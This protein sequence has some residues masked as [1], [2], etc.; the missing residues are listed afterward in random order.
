M[1]TAEL[2]RQI[3]KHFF[4]FNDEYIPIS[5]DVEMDIIEANMATTASHIGSRAAVG[6][7]TESKAM[8]ILK[9]K[10]K[11]KKWAAV[12]R[13]TYRAFYHTDKYKIM[14]QR[15][16]LKDSMDKILGDNFIC[17]DTYKAYRTEWLTC[18]LMWAK[19]YKL[20]K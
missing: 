6:N 14:R 16:I 12:V 9:L 13:D 7:P 17:Y 19:H 18:A 5:A 20:V 10:E 15:Y 4:N 3:E 8:K 2:K 1:L 11:N